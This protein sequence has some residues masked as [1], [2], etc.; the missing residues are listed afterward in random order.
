MRSHPCV[1]EGRQMTMRGN[2]SQTH[3]PRCRSRNSTSPPTPVAPP[4]R[5]LPPSTSSSG[6]RPTE[7]ATRCWVR[8]TQHRDRC[9]GSTRRS[10]LWSA[11]ERPRVR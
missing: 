11:G 1:D 5:P 2:D 6:L 9:S 4:A 8:E 10:Q 3:G 7:D